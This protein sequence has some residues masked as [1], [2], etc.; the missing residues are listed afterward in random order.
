[1]NS[2]DPIMGRRSTGGLMIVV[3]RMSKLPCS[4]SKNQ[5]FYH[6]RNCAFNG[7]GLSFLKPNFGS[8]WKGVAVAVAVAVGVPIIG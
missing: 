4:L 6:A 2:V 5:M 8:N 3:H 7:L 1:M